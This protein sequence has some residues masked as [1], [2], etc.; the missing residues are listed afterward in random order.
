MSEQR[1]RPV[2]YAVWLIFASV[3]GWFAAFQLTV[4]KFALLENP[5]EALS[6]DLSPFLQCSTN[7]QSY[8]GSIFG[9]PNPI[10]GLT[11]WMAPLVVGVAILAGARFPRWFWLTFGAG[12][13]F[14]FGFVIWLIGQS[15]Y[16]LL[17][18][19][20][21]CMVTW[22]VTIPTFFA[23]MIHLTRIGAFTSNEKVQARA[24][25]LMPWVPLATIVAYALVIFLA[26]LQGLDFLGE[27]AKILF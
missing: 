7:L 21:W 6:C 22:A 5:G 1:T 20:P 14:A 11:G 27:I 9:F 2:V 19:C 17:V 16:E 8:Q 4:E 13:T 26:Q 18:L 10:L 24:D 25:K 15:L 12:I 23:T 3:V